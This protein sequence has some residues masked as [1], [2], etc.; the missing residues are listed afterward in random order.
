M[1]LEERGLAVTYEKVQAE[2]EKPLEPVRRLII[3]E[4]MQPREPIE[5]EWRLEEGACIVDYPKAIKLEKLEV[6]KEMPLE[7]LPER[8]ERVEIKQ[9]KQP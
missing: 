3:E 2:Y 8:L 7:R 4:E 6:Q 1:P 5:F 9:E